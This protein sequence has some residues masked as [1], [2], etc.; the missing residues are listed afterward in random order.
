MFYHKNFHMRIFHRHKKNPL[1]TNWTEDQHSVQKKRNS[2]KES[3]ILP[4]VQSGKR[5]WILYPLNVNTSLLH[6]HFCGLKDVT[7]GH[8]FPLFKS[9]IRLHLSI[10]HERFV[11]VGGST[12]QIHNEYACASAI[13]AAPHR[14]LR[15]L[16]LDNKALS[17]ESRNGAFLECW[18]GEG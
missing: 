5:T 9:R 18:W 4:C 11:L 3:N 7:E 15:W 14:L 8:A 16:R 17:V 1:E 13:F 6:G 12:L 10:P 2:P